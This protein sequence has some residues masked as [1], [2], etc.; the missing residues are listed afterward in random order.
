MTLIAVALVVFALL[1]APL[2]AIFG[3]A[4]IALF[5]SLPEGT[6]ASVAID[7]F[8]ARF[9]DSPT[10]MT[11]PLFTFSGYLLAESGTPRRLVE[12]SKA[13]LG[14]MPGGLAAV[15]LMASAFFTTF[16]GGSGVTI[17]AVG[18]LLL[19]ALISERYPE[20]FSLGLI[21]AGGSLGLLFPPSVP[22]I[23]YGL[24]AG[25]VVD[26]VLLAGVLPGV[27]TV[28]ALVIHAGFVGTRARV[29]STPFNLSRALKAL[30]VSGWEVA[31][32]IWLIGGLAF[33]LFRIHEASAFAAVYVLLTQVLLY[34]DVS[35]R[36][37]LPRIV[38]ESM[39][40]VG[41][42][43]AILATAIGFVGW[44]VQAQIPTKLVE[45]M[46]SVIT[47]PVAFLL[48]LNVFLLFVGM[49]MDIFSAIVVVVPLIL[50]LAYAYGVDPYHLAIIFLLN[51][52]IGYLTPPVGINLFI[53]SI[54]F[55]KPVTYLYRSV[56]PFIGILVVA[57][58][59]V[60]YVPWLSTYLPSLIDVDEERSLG[61]HGG[62]VEQPLS[63]RDDELPRASDEPED[64][65]MAGLFD[66][67]EDAGVEDA[68]DAKEEAASSD[69][70]KSSVPGVKTDAQAP[71]PSQPDTDAG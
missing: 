6:M 59:I 42:I 26:K 46:E 45:L 35:I 50:P 22:L 52:E 39:T 1:G 18:G 27:I 53:S 5:M 55:E 60:T 21:T 29:P 11:I 34:R 25:L 7:V 48:V 19:P 66:D 23:L 47:S 70:S 15:C 41:A 16:T 3:A 36:E 62:A 54:R 20:R 68:G 32:P 14:W 13:W 64:D 28:L 17:I 71:T 2:Y 38:R 61:R 12:L 43:L 30:W 9:A 44:L 51:L 69:H 4:S 57:L 10:L 24:I 67:D 49:L 31:I 40:L 58:L 33:G 65:I 8:S 63:G 56:L 37:D